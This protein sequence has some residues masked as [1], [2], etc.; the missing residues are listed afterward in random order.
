M[1]SKQIRQRFIDFFVQH[2]HTHCPSSSLIPAQDATLLFANAG[3]NQFKD[4][5]LGKETAPYTRAVTAQKCVR[6]GGKHN[7]LDNV[8]FT[9]RHLTFFEML[10]NFSFGDYF[11]REAITYAWQFLTQEMQLPISELYVSIYKDDDESY[12]LWHDEIGIPANK[13][14]RLGEQEN[15]WS[16]GDLGPCGPCTEIHIDR[17]PAYGCPTIEQCGPA[18]DCDRFLE[19]W[20]LVFMQYDRQQDGSLKPLTK[21]G[22][23]TGMGLERLTSIMQHVDSVFDTDLFVHIRNHIE[24]QTNKKYSEQS[25]EVQ[26]AFRVIE[27]HIRSS[28][29]LIADGCTPANEGRGYVLR[30]IIRRAALFGRKLTDNK[31][32]MPALAG[33]FAESFGE[34]YPE[35]RIHKGHIMMVI[36]DEVDRFCENC[37]RGQALFEKY[38]SQHIADKQ[39]PGDQAFKLYDTYGFP[40]ELITLMARERG[41]SVDMKGFEC[42][43]TEQQE[44][45]GKPEQDAIDYMRL[46]CSIKSVFTGYESL[47]TTTSVIALIDDNLAEQTVL[48]AGTSG[49]VV[50]KQSPFF[51]LGGGQERDRGSIQV[52][53]TVVPVDDLRLISGIIAINIKAPA[54][55][56]IGDVVSLHVD[57]PYRRAIMRNHTATHLLQAALRELFDANVKQAGSFVAADYV[58]FDFSSSKQLSPALLN[59]VEQL[60]NEKIQENQTLCIEYMPIEEAKKRG[61][62]A[63]FEDRYADNQVRV[64]SVPGF[65]AELCCGTHVKATG[66]I[67]TFKITELKSIAAGTRRIVAVTGDMAIKLFQENFDQLKALSSLFEVPQEQLTEAAKGCK[68]ELKNALHELKRIRKEAQHAL[69]P[70]WL[71]KAREIKGI[72]VLYIALKNYQA[73]E[74]KEAAEHLV[75]AKPGLYLLVSETEGKVLFCAHVAPSYTQQANMKQLRS[76]LQEHY[77]L[78]GGGSETV[79]QGGAHAMPAGLE[80]ALEAWLSSTPTSETAAKTK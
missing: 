57:E 9:K 19:I 7:D 70:V 15:F 41:F 42:A 22:V 67:G 30:K 40:V 43:M 16:M 25:P 23:D 65:S 21:T 34:I 68:H 78:H 18:C 27:D 72:P 1:E 56:H 54:D 53:D 58:R 47:E 75:Q 28:S 5:F 6:A 13:I 33:A 46:P 35:L 39:I 44:R 73:Q 10:G 45:S 24:I 77:K 49:W 55:L 51:V 66:D 80:T 31:G 74:L 17:G 11:K 20:N 26:A 36:K 8:G 64:V 3:M 69:I 4:I 59:R 60:I 79:L 14:Y 52:G 12:A 29:M 63:F 37:T 61:A 38:C 2:G 32:L 62:L 71:T 50:T 48:S 76:F